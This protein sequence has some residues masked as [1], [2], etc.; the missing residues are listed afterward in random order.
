MCVFLC[1]LSVFCA[2][3]VR[4]LSCLSSYDPASQ[5]AIATGLVA[6]LGAGASEAQEHVTEMLMTL[7]SDMP[8]R[9]PQPHLQELMAS[10][11]ARVPPRLYL[12]CHETS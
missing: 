3:C 9:P 12:T 1:C 6:L 5:L 10:P 4:A 11:R 8:S 7:A 2:F